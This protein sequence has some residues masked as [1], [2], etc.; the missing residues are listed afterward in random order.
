LTS[1]TWLGFGAG[2]LLAAVAGTS[3]GASRP[4]PYLSLPPQVRPDD[5]YHW[6]FRIQI[7]N[8]LSK[9]LY[10]DSLSCD[11]EDLDP[12][13]TRIPR[14]QRLSLG[15]VTEIVRSVSDRDSGH[16]TFSATA[17]VEHAR[18][19]FRLYAHDAKGKPYVV[20]GVT[21]SMPNEA[22]ANLPSKYFDRG[23]RRIEYVLVPPI[24]PAPSS[25]A[26]LLVHGHG[27]HARQLI[28]RALLLSEKKYWVMLVSQ[29]G[30]GQ[31]Q[32]P[33]DLMGPATV[34]ALEGALDILEHVPGV[35]STRVAAW[36]I[37]RGATAVTLLAQR[38][39]ELRA[40]VAQS[41][42][43][44]LWAT[45]RG[46]R[47]MGFPETIVREAGKDSAAWR[48]RSPITASDRIRSAVLILHGEQDENV[49]V[50]QAHE[51]AAA[52]ERRGAAVETRF[53]WNQAH[54]LPSAE[55]DKTVFDFLERRLAAPAPEGAR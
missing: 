17:G 47:V 7:F 48:E 38:R 36:G 8:P 23:G 27:S 45:Y 4:A 49:P 12:G 2:L 55:V 28:A 42:I 13:E 15:G 31:S 46:T 40:L 30:Y 54:A 26:I 37:S 34:G 35:D 22:A 24:R 44:D 29:P 53:F 51:F 43:Y 11:I 6:W 18:L 19:T 25:P 20:T 1:S 3:A 33:A 32:G 14:V 52:L 50:D 16:V 10:T 5:N 39:P 41:G 9:G 21:E